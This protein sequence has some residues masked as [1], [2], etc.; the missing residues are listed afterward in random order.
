MGR[1]ARLFKAT[2]ETP[3][4]PVVEHV[5]DDPW[6]LSTIIPDLTWVHQLFAEKARRRE[7]ARLTLASLIALATAG[8]SVMR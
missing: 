6:W 4:A 2:P 5:V 3:R 1:E 8:R 7:H